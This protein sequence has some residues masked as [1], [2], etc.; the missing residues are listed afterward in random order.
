MSF[1]LER[2]CEDKGVFGTL[3]RTSVLSRMKA[4]SGD[5]QGLE[6]MSQQPLP[7]IPSVSTRW[8]WRGCY[9][10]PGQAGGVL[11]EE[12]GSVGNS[13]PRPGGDGGRV[14]LTGFSRGLTH[15][16]WDSGCAARKGGYLRV[17]GALVGMGLPWP[18][19]ACHESGTAARAVSLQACGFS[20]CPLA[21]GLFIFTWPGLVEN[22]SC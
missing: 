14:R 10:P 15:G 11:V 5:G 6:P 21:Q 7:A 3:Q 8:R 12:Q 17:T 13:R 18:A 19:G 9:T 22:E 1:W 4:L 2:A 16:Q 20:Q